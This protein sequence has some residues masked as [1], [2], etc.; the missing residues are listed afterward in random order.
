MKNTGKTTH[1]HRFAIHKFRVNENKVDTS[2]FQP[3]HMLMCMLKNEKM[4]R[5]QV[6]HFLSVR[7]ILLQVHNV[8][9]HAVNTQLRDV[10]HLFGWIW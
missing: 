2:H 5:R 1:T 8:K 4:H 7:L 9:M 10:C 6:H 3:F